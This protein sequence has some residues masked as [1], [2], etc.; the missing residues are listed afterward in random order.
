V[1]GREEKAEQVR[2]N[3]EKGE[4]GEKRENDERGKDLLDKVEVSN[5]GRV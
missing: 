4:K 3:E 5:D 1:C 2:T